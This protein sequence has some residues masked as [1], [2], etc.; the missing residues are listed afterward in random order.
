M[1]RAT[2]AQEGELL[3]QF[4]Q[5]PNPTL[6]DPRDLLLDFRNNVGLVLED[7]LTNARNPDGNGGTYWGMTKWRKHQT[8]Q[9]MRAQDYDLKL[10]DS[11]DSPVNKVYFAAF[12]VEWN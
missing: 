2:F 3:L 10:T 4:F 7:M 1:E 9:L 6:T 12:I 5:L 8:P 11:D